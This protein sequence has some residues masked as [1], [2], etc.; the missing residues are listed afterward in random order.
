[1][2]FIIHYGL[3]F[4]LPA[5]ISVAFFKKNWKKAYLIMLATM[6]VDLDHLLS[7]PIYQADRCSIGFHPLHTYY[8]IISYGIMIFFRKPFNIIGVG[9]LLHMSTDLTD[10][11][12]TYSS[13][14]ECLA[15]APS[16]ELIKFIFQVINT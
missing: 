2:Q 9:L 14:K 5:L 10:C 7:S 1:M 12:I 6:L 11:L 8:A 4:L 13:C 15:D 3:H 16:L